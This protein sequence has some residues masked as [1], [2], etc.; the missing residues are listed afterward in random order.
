MP[1]RVV[2]LKIDGRD[3]TARDDQMLIDV[4]RENDIRIP[5]LCYVSGLSTYGGC[6]LCLVEVEGSSKLLAACTTAVA[7]GIEVRTVTERLTEYRR[8]ILEMLFAERNHVCSVCISNGH[9]EM[10]SL[11]Q[12]LGIDHIRFPYVY[13]KLPVDASH[14]R[15]VLDQNRCILC[16]RC[17]RV[18]SEIEGAHT[19]DIMG[20]GS[21]CLVITDLAQPWAEAESC[22]SCG[23]CVQV[24]PTGALS[25][26]GHSVAEMSKRRQF[27]PYLTMMRDESD[28]GER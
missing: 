28:G 23:K 18:C 13:P 10:Q 26:K 8:M 19:W 4:A 6:R 25:E 12:H 2:T 17:V 9:C 11:A 1:A 27:L 14:D 24:C 7:E 21:E 22:T 20:R 15:F 3:V 16:T 5:K